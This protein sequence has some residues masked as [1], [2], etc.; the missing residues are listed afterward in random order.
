MHILQ[1][2]AEDVSGNLIC[3]PIS[4]SM[5]LSMAA[6]GARGET[7]Q[8]LRTALALP[9]D[10]TVTKT[11]FQ[12]LVD[13]FKVSLTKVLQ[14][15]IQKH[16]QLMKFKDI[17]IVLCYS[18]YQNYKQVELRLANK[19]FLAT[20]FEP[21]AEFK[22]V[23]GTSFRSEAQ[24]LD[25]HKAIEAS[26]TINDWCEE[27]TNHRIKDLIKPGKIIFNRTIFFTTKFYLQV[28]LIVC[29]PSQAIFPLTLLSY[30]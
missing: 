21:K 18:M 7:E 19:M 6:F 5:V 22:E 3:S 16:L 20:G 25:F 24:S 13:S 12:S 17:N 4:A 10:D 2:V 30:S 29:F 14:S 27:Q 28:S 9:S 23:T 1:A 8:K 11:G 15:S 26:K